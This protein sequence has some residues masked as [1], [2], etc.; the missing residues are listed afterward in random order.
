MNCFDLKF[1]NRKFWVNWVLVWEND[2]VGEIVKGKSS[3]YCY[4]LYFRD[5]ESEVWRVLYMFILL[6]KRECGCRGCVYKF[7]LYCF[8]WLEGIV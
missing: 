1:E 4:Y 3:V 8:L 2:I 7:I 6:V 5:E